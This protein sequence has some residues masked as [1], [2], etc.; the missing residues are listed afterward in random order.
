MLPRILK[1]SGEDSRW[2]DPQ[3]EHLEDSGG[4]GEVHAAKLDVGARGDVAA[5]P[6]AQRRDLIAQVA[7]LLRRQLAVRHLPAHAC[8]MLQHPSTGN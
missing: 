5:A 1:D 8:I 2:R 3:D 7:Q 6:G 4:L